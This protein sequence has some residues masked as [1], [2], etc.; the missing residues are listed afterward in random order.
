MAKNYKPVEY[1]STTFESRQYYKQQSFSNNDDGIS[2]IHYRS[3]SLNFSDTSGVSS[4]T[5]S[6]SH[7]SFLK[8]LL[9]DSASYLGYDNIFKNKFPESGSVGYIP[10]QYYGEEIKPNSFRLIDGLIK[11]RDDGNGNLYSSNAV[12]SR[13]AASP[14]SS[15][16][17]YIGNIQYQ[18][19]I[20]TINETGSWSGSGAT[21]T[22]VMYTNIGNGDFSVRF[23]ATQ[24]IHQN[25]IVCKINKN[26][27]TAT[28]NVTIWSGSQGSLI[29]EISSS[30]GEW[31]P[32]ATGI[33]FYDKT[34]NIYGQFQTDTYRIRINPGE[35]FIGTWTPETIPVNNSTIPAG[36]T[37]IVGEGLETYLQDSVWTGTLD[38]LYTGKQ[39]TFVSNL[40]Y[41]FVWEARSGEVING[42]VPLIVGKFPRPVKI[43]KET[44]LTIIIRYDI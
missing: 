5:I 14:I 24:T 6:G 7:Y 42:G 9:F 23:N 19:G 17:N 21:A 27:F 30:L 40:E 37:G 29:S 1:A 13:S 8:N 12:N 41:S 26:E 2:S 20:V 35:N 25:E 34:P 33:A 4:Y 38:Y 3:E 43:D 36:I 31:T 44:D 22:D 10:Q 16:E 39:Y 11:I 32:Y 28:S 18:M 15:S